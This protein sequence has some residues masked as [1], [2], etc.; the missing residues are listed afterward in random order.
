MSGSM[1]WCRRRYIQNKQDGRR[2]DADQGVSVILGRSQTGKNPC[3]HRLHGCRELLWLGCTCHCVHGLSNLWCTAGG[4]PYDAQGNTRD[5]KF[6]LR[7][8][9]GDSNDFMGASL[10]VKTQGL[11]QGNGAAPAGWAVISIT[12]S[13]KDTGPSF[14]TLLLSSQSHCSS[15]FCGC[16][17]CPPHQPGRCGDSI[18]HP[19]RIASQH[20]QLGKA[21]CSLRGVAQAFKV[22]LSHTI[23]WLEAKW[24]LTQCQ[25]PPEWGISNLYPHTG[26]QNGANKSSIYTWSDQDSGH[27]DKSIWSSHESNSK[28]PEPGS[29]M[30][31]QGEE[32]H[33]APPPGM[34]G[35]ECHFWP[36]VGY[37]LSG[38]AAPFSVLA[39]GLDKPY[40]SLLL[41]GGVACSC[42]TVV[43]QL[44]MGF[45][46]IGLPQLGVENCIWYTNKLLIHYGCQTSAGIQLQVSM[47]FLVMELGMSHQAFL[48]NYDHYFHLLTSSWLKY[49]WEKDLSPSA[50]EG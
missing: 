31:W 23:V 25:E 48:V 26:G 27:Y 10:D 33:D 34:F 41:H 9:F 35:L 20:H 38:V 44:D 1:A 4:S 16:H 15:P 12:I 42:W 5:M 18:T 3:R 19:H 29:G 8:A 43:R 28:N 49:L 22:F 2:W 6:F 45:Y 13:I 21:A 11:C 32:G 39:E 30:G 50:G 14:Y 24:H 46:G 37:G 47:E 7:T 17:R 40:Y 36:K